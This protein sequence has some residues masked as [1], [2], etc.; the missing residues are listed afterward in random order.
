MNHWTVLRLSG[1]VWNFFFCCFFFSFLFFVFVW[2]LSKKN[3]MCIPAFPY[4]FLSRMDTHIIVRTFRERE[5]GQRETKRN[6][7][8]TQCIRDR[9][10]DRETW[11]LV[12]FLL[13]IFHEINC[14]FLLDIFHEI[15][16]PFQGDFG[17]AA[18]FWRLRNF[19]TALIILREAR[20]VQSSTISRTYPD[21]L[22]RNVTGKWLRLFPRL[23]GL[24]GKV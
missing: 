7:R 10:T 20:S 21:F 6:R 13:Y 12:H 22:G 5:G 23:W 19:R 24:S 3:S 15:T 4:H 14:P 8:T 17:A 2:T 9:Q 16:C 1:S 18:V 11:S